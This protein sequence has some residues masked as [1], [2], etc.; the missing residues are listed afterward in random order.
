MD[1]PEQLRLRCSNLE[2]AYRDAYPDTVK[3][4]RQETTDKIYKKLTDYARSTNQ[5]RV[6]EVIY[7][8]IYHIEKD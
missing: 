2:K 5:S 8:A 4:V 3:R 1:E 7:N 6:M